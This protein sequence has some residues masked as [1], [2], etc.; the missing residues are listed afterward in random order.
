MINKED[1]RNKLSDLTKMLSISNDRKKVIFQYAFIDHDPEFDYITESSEYPL[2]K[3]M[4]DRI[5]EM[6]NEDKNNLNRDFEDDIFI[7]L[8]NEFNLND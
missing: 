7:Q 1:I 2:L 8:L 5:V 3:R 4:I 6:I